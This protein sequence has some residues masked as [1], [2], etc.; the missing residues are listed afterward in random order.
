MAIKHTAFRECQQ[1]ID[2]DGPDGNANM[3]IQ[4]AD[5]TAH[6]LDY[7]KDERKK[8][9]D[10]MTSS[11]YTHLVLTFDEHFGHYFTL[12]TKNEEIIKATLKKDK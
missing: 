9:K 6:Q 8:L 10:D 4:L 7:N 3:M 1:D 11:D 2:L 12:Y 5:S